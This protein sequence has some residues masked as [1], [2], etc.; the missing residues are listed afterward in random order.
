MPNVSALPNAPHI[1]SP[2]SNRCR[3]RRNVALPGV[4]CHTVY[5]YNHYD[6]DDTTEP[7]PCRHCLPHARTHRHR[8]PSRTQTHA[9]INQ[10]QAGTV[11]AQAAAAETAEA[12]AAVAQVVVSSAGHVLHVLSHSF[13]LVTQRAT[14]LGVGRLLA[15][16]VRG[17]TAVSSGQRLC[18][19]ALSVG[20]PSWDSVL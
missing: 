17:G 3:G 11:R 9:R 6:D 10:W 7:P 16:P 14:L 1:V 2:L 15:Q 19:T 4:R 18:S 8:N 12:A 13:R 20:L 5:Y